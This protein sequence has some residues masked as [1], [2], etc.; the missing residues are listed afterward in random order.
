MFGLEEQPSAG[1][2]Q[3]R[4]VGKRAAQVLVK[5]TDGSLPFTI[6]GVLF[7]NFLFLHML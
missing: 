4:T 2:S 3:E 5:F 1:W 6:F 7:T